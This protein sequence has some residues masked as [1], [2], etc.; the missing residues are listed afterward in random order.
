MSDLLTLRPNADSTPLEQVPSSGGSGAHY[1][2]IDEASKDES[3]Y[4]VPSSPVATA[5]KI[6]I[7]GFPDHTSEAGVINSVAVKC[8]CN[9]A[10]VGTDGTAVYVNPAVKVGGTLY[11]GGAQ[12]LTT[13]VSLYSYSWANNPATVA[14]WTWDEIDALLA[15]DSLSTHLA[16]KGNS[17]NGYLYQLWVEV[18]YEA[19]VGNPMSIKVGGSLKASSSQMIKVNGVWRAVAGHKIKIG[20]AWK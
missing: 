8:Y 2:K 14:A 11:Y 7:Y 17:R 1:E 15:G 12:E 6:D 3:D 4:M 5:T 10:L 18:S 16:S 9:Y 19:E 13:T 20:G